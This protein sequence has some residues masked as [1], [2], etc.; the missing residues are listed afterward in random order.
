MIEMN[1]F[2]DKELERVYFNNDERDT[3]NFAIVYENG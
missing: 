1:L 2:F 3:T